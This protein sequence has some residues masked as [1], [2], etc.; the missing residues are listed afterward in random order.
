MLV[1]MARRWSTKIE[2]P[3]P[4]QLLAV[5]YVGESEDPVLLLILSQS[6]F[7]ILLRRRSYDVVGGIVAT[8]APLY[9]PPPTS[10]HLPPSPPHPNPITTMAALSASALSSRDSMRLPARARVSAR[11]NTRSAVVRVSAASGDGWKSIN[12]TKP[13]IVNNL[14]GET[15]RNIDGKVRVLDGGGDGV[16]RRGVAVD[17]GGSCVPL[18][19]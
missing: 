10:P 8:P 5:R 3:T 13:N 14:G 15:T 4:R 1:S 7:Q 16:A 2:V 9:A 18:A 12:V 19:L 11:S 6:T 17:A